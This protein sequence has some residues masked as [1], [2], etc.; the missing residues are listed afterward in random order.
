MP[1]LVWLSLAILAGLCI[2]IIIPSFCSI[3]ILT[4]YYI[5]VSESYPVDDKYVGLKWFVLAAIVLS[6][7]WTF[8]FFPGREVTVYLSQ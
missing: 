3:V 5:W 2:D 4:G 7:M 8:D 6:L 1:D